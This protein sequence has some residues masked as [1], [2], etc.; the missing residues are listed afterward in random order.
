MPK[1]GQGAP[2][3]S[4]F[5]DLDLNTPEAASKKVSPPLDAWAADEQDFVS[6]SSASPKVVQPAPTAP[7]GPRA[8]TSYKGGVPDLPESVLNIAERESATLP[9]PSDRESVSAT[10]ASLVVPGLASAPGMAEAGKHV[11]RLLAAVE[12]F[13]PT[14]P[15]KLDSHRLGGVDDVV[16]AFHHCLFGPFKDSKRILDH[17]NGAPA[18]YRE[19]LGQRYEALRGKSLKDAFR[20]LPK[21]ER[22]LA[23]A[24]L[25]HG[26]ASLADCVRAYIASSRGKRLSKDLGHLLADVDT[27]AL[28]IMRGEYRAR[29]GRDPA[30]D[31]KGAVKNPRRRFWIECCLSHGRPT[32]EQQLEHELMR[33]RPSVCRLE[34]ILRRGDDPV[35]TLAKHKAEFGDALTRLQGATL[36]R[37]RLSEQQ[38]AARW[39]RGRYHRD[40]KDLLRTGA[41]CRVHIL[42]DA[43][44]GRIWNQ[45][46]V[47]QVL[48]EASASGQ[49]AEL[50]AEFNRR[51][52]VPLAHL[53]R[54]FRSRKG[55]VC[56][57][58]L[59]TGSLTLI[60]R[61]AKARNRGEMLAAITDASPEERRAVWESNSA[62]YGKG[63]DP[64]LRE[65]LSGTHYLRALELLRHG[66]VSATREIELGLLGRWGRPKAIVRGIYGASEEERQA[67]L[68]NEALMARLE[69]RFTRAQAACIRTVLA[70]GQLR[71]SQVLYYYMHTD[72]ISESMFERAIAYGSESAHGA[73][74]ERHRWRNQAEAIIR[75]YAREFGRDLL[76]DAGRR[77]RPWDV[78]RLRFCLAR[79]LEM[80]SQRAALRAFVATE[81]NG[82]DPLDRL[83]NVI[84]D[85]FNRNRTGRRIEEAWRVYAR[86]YRAALDQGDEDGVPMGLWPSAQNL[87]QLV[88]TYRREKQEAAETARY[89]VATTAGTAC[90]M[91]TAGAAAP[92]TLGAIAGASGAA[93]LVCHRLLRGTSYDL[94]REGPQDF[95]KGAAEGLALHAMSQAN[96]ELS[97]RL[98]RLLVTQELL[99]GAWSYDGYLR[100]GTK[101]LEETGQPVTERAA[102]IA[103]DQLAVSTA[104]AFCAQSLATEAASGAVRGT[105]MGASFN[106]TK[107]FAYAL[108]DPANRDLDLE[109]AAAKVIGDTISEGLQGGRGWSKFLTAFFPA[110]HVTGKLAEAANQTWLSASVAA[111]ARAAATPE[112]L[113][114]EREAIADAMQHVQPWLQEAENHVLGELSAA[115]M[116]ASVGRLEVGSTVTPLQRLASA[117]V[118]LAEDAA[119]RALAMSAMQSFDIVSTQ[120]SPLYAKRERLEAAWAGVVEEAMQGAFQYNLVGAVTAEPWCGGD[121][122]PTGWGG[123]ARA[124]DDVRVQGAVAQLHQ[125]WVEAVDRSL[126]TLDA[127]ESTPPPKKGVAPNDVDDEKVRR[128][129]WVQESSSNSAEAPQASV[130]AVDA[131]E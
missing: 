16:A 77:M 117:G 29:Y 50:E 49:V 5:S 114:L 61:M 75:S 73:G 4:G 28:A 65:K 121:A 24:Y 80:V 56:G 112:M 27:D 43:L 60:D 25:D 20:A 66:G 108:A 113:T 100:L 122:A 42:R 118:V 106:G 120:G 119:A 74:P 52:R 13:E 111:S 11:S 3:S 92:V 23:E 46:K 9:P 55:E 2:E 64:L 72:L 94:R 1:I 115:P 128:G 35:Q 116:D 93:A 62:P 69:R 85:L 58:I 47:L 110:K 91:A 30:H 32:T 39:S 78:A 40:L 44:H 53:C 125:R 38:N 127:T 34:R 87:L 48:E 31:L 10:L 68:A 36:K 83:G 63:V 70:Q 6:T 8:S 81:R 12:V 37:W 131:F 98:G 97:V 84:H 107:A 7:S 101:I 19:L 26:Q 59:K 15:G 129:R 14:P 18:E 109:A 88:A 54:R 99:G 33:R 17:L 76:E 130:S 79:P 103:V 86:E 90:S 21:Y 102:R 104:E 123:I 51:S 96:R 105:V 57:Q 126:D 41:R 82:E 89:I 67:V 22:V 124:A 71:R 95:F 45:A